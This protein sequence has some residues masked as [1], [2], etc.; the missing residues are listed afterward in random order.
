VCGNSLKAP[1]WPLSV[2]VSVNWCADSQPA[3]NSTK[4]H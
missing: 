3:H 2:K 1:D 4:L